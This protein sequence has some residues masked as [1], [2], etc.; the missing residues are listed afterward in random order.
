[1][2]NYLKLLTIFAIISALT[3]VSLVAYDFVKT[4][5]AFPTSTFIAGV[6]VSHLTYREAVNELAQ[7]TAAD[8]FSPLITLEAGAFFYSFPPDILGIHILADK[9]VDRAFGL[10]HKWNYFQSLSERLTQEAIYA[11]LILGIRPEQLRSVLGLIAEDI[12]TDP[13]DASIDL[14]EKTGGY[15]IEPEVVG[16]E[17]KVRQSVERIGAYLAARQK[18]IPLEIE[19]SHPHVSEEAL[20]ANPP[21]YR[22]STYTTYY[23]KHDSPNRIHNIKL[24][25]S[26]VD[27][28]LLMPGDVFSVA[29]ILGEVTPDQGFKEA[30]VIIQGELVPHLGGGSCQIATT[31]YNAVSLA[32]LKVVE[33]R[34]HSFYFNIYPLGRDAAVYPGQIDFKFENDTPHPLLLRSAATG[35]SLTFRVYGSPSGKRVRFSKTEIFGKGD[36]GNFAPMSLEEVIENDI[37][38]RT[39]VLRTVFYRNRIL[40]QDAIL[41]RYK[42][43]GDKDSVPI[44]RPEPR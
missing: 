39:K 40:K 20:R 18:E 12:D 21:V 9:T 25:S 19:Y 7:H 34:N 4:R 15:H 1:M 28:T 37:P 43:Y 38:F 41:S 11:P 31:L 30:F 16:R 32:D 5:R 2:R 6:D 23:G 26:W 3:A 33:R 10:T 42:L 24:V 29:E 8:L 14:D 22:L 44:R 36:D 27:G 13:Q 17:L 35:R